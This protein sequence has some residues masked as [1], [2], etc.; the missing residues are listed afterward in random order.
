MIKHQLDLSIVARASM[1]GVFSTSPE[2]LLPNTRMCSPWSGQ[3]STTSLIPYGNDDGGHFSSFSGHV[4]VAAFTSG[5]QLL[6]EPVGHR[7]IWD[8][9]PSCPQSVERKDSNIRDER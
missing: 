2:E 4:P 6:P 9:L 8:G 3:M 7:V 5:P 1:S